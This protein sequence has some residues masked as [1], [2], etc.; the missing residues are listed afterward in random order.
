MKKRKACRSFETL[1]KSS[2]W[3]GQFVNGFR[4]LNVVQRITSNL[5]VSFGIVLDLLVFLTLALLFG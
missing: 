1:L 4:A 2:N 3:E 5:T